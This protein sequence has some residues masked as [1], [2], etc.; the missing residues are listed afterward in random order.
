MLSSRQ[1][2]YPRKVVV[3][4]NKCDVV[5]KNKHAFSDDVDGEEIWSVLRR[6][7]DYSEFEDAMSDMPVLF[8]SAVKNWNVEA[9][10]TE[11]CKL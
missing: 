4:I 5:Y 10:K 11:F 8:G 1:I 2:K 6:A 7:V 9:L 3:F